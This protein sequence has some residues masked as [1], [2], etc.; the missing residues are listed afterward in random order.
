MLVSC[1]YL[2]NKLY[3]FSNGECIYYN[4]VMFP[5][6]S[7]PIIWLCSSLFFKFETPIIDDF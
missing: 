2:Q 3:Y 7:F 1:W 5:L 6:E 4:I